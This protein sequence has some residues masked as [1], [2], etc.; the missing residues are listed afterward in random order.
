MPARFKR[1][2]FCLLLILCL[3]LYLSGFAY[4]EGACAHDFSG[5]QVIIQEA[6]CEYPGVIEIACVNNCGVN[7]RETIPPLGHSFSGEGTVIRQPSCTQSGE[8][9]YVCQN[10]CA[11][12]KTEE[13]PALG[14]DYPGEPD[15]VSGASC[16]ENGCKTWYCRNGCSIVKNET[17]PAIG[18]SFEGEGRIVQNPSCTE[19]GAAEYVCRNGCGTVYT[20]EI[21]A[22]GHDFSG[23]AVIDKDASCTQDGVRTI[24]CINGCGEVKTEVIPMTG[25]TFSDRGSV[26]KEASCTLSGA[27]VYPCEN[28]CGETIREEIPP[29]GHSFGKWQEVYASTCTLNGRQRRVCAYCGDSE[30]RNAPLLPHTPGGF[31]CLPSKPGEIGIK[32]RMC[33]RCL[34]VLETRMDPASFESYA[35]DTGLYENE[36]IFALDGDLQKSGCA[37]TVCRIP[38]PDFECGEKTLLSGYECLTDLYY[39]EIQH[40]GASETSLPG[41]VLVFAA[42][43]AVIEEEEPY[44]LIFLSASDQL[45]GDERVFC[46]EIGA[47]YE[48]FIPLSFAVSEGYIVIAR[49]L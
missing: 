19:D 30:T 22:F 36:L 26:S 21:P 28:G 48:E 31:L 13:I 18:H 32:T 4:S 24:A 14:H 46:Q 34:K 39:I 42:Y 25:H 15:S 33:G 44:E 1:M 8:K 7:R 3:I 40:D 35:L 11:G 6:A 37:L 29:R 23:N 20:E 49:K 45:I 10:G 17:I 27:M 41:S 43:D 9:L 38:V 12:T 16:T 5:R 47:P 2:H